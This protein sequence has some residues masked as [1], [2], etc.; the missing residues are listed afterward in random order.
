[1][2]TDTSTPI[3]DGHSLEY[4]GFRFELRA[5]PARGAYQPIVV[6]VR[7]PADEEETQ[8]P[9]DTEEIVYGTEAE[10]I[11]HA[12]QQA[13]RWVHDRTGDGQAQF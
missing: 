4:R 12:E 7:T 2:P 13:M 10:A 5:E 8:L 1:M 9:N 6:L 11:R 3:S